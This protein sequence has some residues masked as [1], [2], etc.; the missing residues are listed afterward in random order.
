[1]FIVST[2]AQIGKGSVWLGGSIGFNQSKADNT[3]GIGHQKIKAFN[4][5]PA[6]GIAIKENLIAGVRLGYSKNTSENNPTPTSHYNNTTENYGG[7]IFIRRYVPVINRLYIFGEGTA[8]YA[9]SKITKD[10][11][12][13]NETR[14]MENKGW[15]TS[16]GF[17]PGVSYGITKKLQ[18][19]TGFNS[20]FGMSYGKSK[21][22]NPDIPSGNKGT[23]EGFSAG[24][25]LENASTFYIGF[26]VLLN[27]KG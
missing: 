12:Y 23:S 20:L 27:N 13:N 25:S 3:P 15:S 11:L 22:T 4:V 24:I 6:I 5:S 17:T 9:R 7:G 8:S 2:R 18:L 26:R 16:L 14:A 10:E 21:E 19:E 1:M